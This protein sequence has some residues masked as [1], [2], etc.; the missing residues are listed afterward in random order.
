MSF[1]RTHLA[2]MTVYAA[3]VA[4]FFALLWKETRRDRLRTFLLI[5]FSLFL[6]GVALGWAMYPFPR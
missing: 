4:L 1:L 3:A 2:L 6:G 5:F